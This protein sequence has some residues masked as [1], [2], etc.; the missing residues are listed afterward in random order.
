[1]ASLER[2]VAHYMVATGDLSDNSTEIANRVVHLIN[3][4]SVQEN[5][6]RLIQSMGEYLTNE[7]DA[8]RSRATGLLSYTL[9]QCEQE[10]I[11]PSAVSV[12]VDFYCE[13]LTEKSNLVHLLNGLAALAEFEHF[14]AMNAILVAKKLYEHL[15]VQ[16]FPQGTRNTVFR[17]FE[18]LLERHTPALKTINN[19]FISGFIQMVDGEK[20][21]RNLMCAFKLI[22]SIIEH[23]D[24]S[25]HVED[26]FEVTF[27]YFPITFKPPP[28][29]P[30]GITSDDIKYSL[31]RCISSTAQFSKLAVPLLLE[32]LSSTSGSAKKDSMETLATCAPVYGAAALL[33][34]IDEILEALKLEV[35]H[36][37]DQA[38]EDT[39]LDCI[40]SIITTLSTSV[41]N[42]VDDPTE[43]ALRPLVEECVTHLKDP[44]LKN[45]KPSS[46]LLRAVASASDPACHYAVA[47]VVPML[48][49][50]H[51]ETEVATRKKA[52]LDVLNECLEATREVYGSS[53]SDI[54]E[55]EQDLVSPLNDYK[56][57]FFAMFESALL[58]S[59]EYS[60]LRLTGLKGLQG[61]V[62]NRHYLDPSEM[63]SVIQ[64]FNRVLVSELDEELRSAA[65]DALCAISTW[66]TTFLVELTVPALIHQLPETSDEHPTISQP[67]TLYAI[68]RLCSEPILFQ[69]A[70]PMLMTKFHSV[71][72]TGTTHYAQAILATLLQVIKNKASHGHKDIGLYMDL[73]LNTL[74]TDA[75]KASLDST[76]SQTI[77]SESIVT[78][79]SLVLVNTFHQVDIV[80]QKNY[81]DLTFDLFFNGNL[82]VI[83]LPRSDAFAPFKATS[84]DTQKATSPLFSAILSTCRKEI[85][86]PLDNVEHFID[87]LVGLA[88]ETS[89]TAQLNALVR[90]MGSLMNKWKE[91]STLT[92]HAEKISCWLEPI[93]SQKGPQSPNAMC[94]Y[95]WMTKALVMKAHTM[96]Y[97]FTDKVIEWCSDASYN[98]QAPQGFGILMGEDGLALDKVSF[99]TMTI[100]YKQ[101]FFSHCLPQL[102][103]GFQGA[104]RE[105]KH[106]YL[107]ALSYLLKNV[108]KQILL[109]ELPPLIPLLIQSLSLEDASL[110]IS[111]LAT[112]QISIVEAPEAIAPHLRTLLHAILD[113]LNSDE[114]A[115]LSVRL[116]SLQC[117]SQFPQSPAR[118]SLV[119][120]ANHVTKHLSKSVGDRKRIVRKEAVECRAQW[121]SL[122]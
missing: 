46:R 9:R 4:S 74:V 3:A 40:Q 14:S 69:A 42:S 44:E 115:P 77:L 6:L 2:E 73:F 118:E 23:F 98:G 92:I 121:Y 59:N 97:V 76:V 117:L 80:S 111:T 45:A 78:M 49:C 27:C 95:L 108:P 91:S 99:A 17:V 21:P 47:S 65:L 93:I 55:M 90:M 51:Q 75:V 57:R 64:S 30:Y 122:L 26:L 61:M 113:I 53:D 25:G 39:A 32:K 60:E 7:D 52:I 81:I 63:G 72:Q 101:R 107:I 13:R 106:N 22:R 19:E 8:V 43:R 36:A 38:L 20:D 83:G 105:V 54:D 28:D 109:N 16:R 66:N 10:S 79:I 94:I 116:A 104:D 85:V 1:M 24:I 103:H 18:S 12:L 62:L 34:N 87:Q 120:H 67:Q 96:G 88:L 15:E 50:Y 68:K 11:V 37:T 5:L 102:V 119:L 100:L 58:A 70:T 110:K 82:T 112:F 33:P 31:R 89:H 114:M 35:F 41:S 56:D 86:Y 29:D 48:V 84:P 71:C